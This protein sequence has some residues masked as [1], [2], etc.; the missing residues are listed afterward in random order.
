MR[1]H[2]AGEDIDVFCSKCQ[3][4]L[5]HVIVAIAR[6]KVARVQCKTCG[7]VHAYRAP[8][9]ARARRSSDGSAGAR[10]S[11]R[12][13]AARPDY[14][15]LMRGRDISRA[16]RYKPTVTYAEGDVLS[17]PSFG[18]GLVTRVLDD[19]KLEVL[20]RAGSKVLVHARG[21]A[22]SS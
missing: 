18:L 12:G 20:F 2:K 7:S 13:G 15:G 16:Q 14:D 1:T 8:A 22:T 4:E 10:S 9:D 21:S 5:A 19:G 6:G 3:L 11:A 17:H